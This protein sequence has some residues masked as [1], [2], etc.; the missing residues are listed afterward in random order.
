MMKSH[1]LQCVRRGV[2]R[3][4]KEEGALSYLSMN[5]VIRTDGPVQLVKPRRGT[6]KGEL[7]LCSEEQTRISN[8]TYSPIPLVCIYF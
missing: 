1:W 3:S 8:E 6:R 2:E 5:A 4:Y 7:D